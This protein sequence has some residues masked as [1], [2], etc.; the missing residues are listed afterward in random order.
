MAYNDKENMRFMHP[1]F[2]KVF[3]NHQP[4]DFRI[5]NLIKKRQT[6]WHLNDPIIW[7]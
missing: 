5:I 3:K 1:H 2:Q 7:D 6:I 4:M